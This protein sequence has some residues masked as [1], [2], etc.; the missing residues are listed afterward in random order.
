MPQTQ[1][2]ECLWH[3]PHWERG[4][5]WQ[6]VSPWAPSHLAGRLLQWMCAPRDCSV[7]EKD[8]LGPRVTSLP[9]SCLYHLGLL[10][11]GNDGSPCLSRIIPLS[12]VVLLDGG[13]QPSGSGYASA[14][15]AGD[16]AL[17]LPTIPSDT[18]YT[19]EGP[20]LG[21]PSPAS[22]PPL[23]CK[24]VVPSPVQA[25]PWPT[26]IHSQSERGT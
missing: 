5:I 2:T 6:K 23:V 25:L 26:M 14:H 21:S 7:A 8:S 12:P 15:L 11:Q 22:S 17:C 3:L 9:R 13:D 20:P 19:S 4:P 18:P 1:E 10:L 24:D 16:S